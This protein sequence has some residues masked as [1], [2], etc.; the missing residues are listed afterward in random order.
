MA[1]NAV[2]IGARGTSS[3]S[4]ATTTAGTSTGGSG[5]HGVAVVSFDLGVTVTTPVQD[6]KGNTF[7]L[8]GTMQSDASDGRMSVYVCENWT[9]GASHS[10]TV[11]FSG[12]AF[13]VVHLVEV[14]GAASA[15]PIDINVQETDTVQP[16]A[17]N[18]GTLSQAA[19]VVLICGC[20]NEVSPDG[21]Y[22]TTTGTILS[23]EPSFTNFWTSGVAKQVT[24][25]TTDTAYDIRRASPVT[26]GGGHI[27]LVSFKEAAA[28]GSTPKGPLGNPLSGPF[29][30]PI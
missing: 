14:T 16:M 19:E 6:S 4:S 18:S 15:S 8:Q 12:T 23:S 22:T 11:A 20:A 17:A 26:T 27:H 29:G 9:G 3:G 21:E 25:A 28:G 7:T 30:G 2:L 10:I 24:A 5:N 1:I 13:P